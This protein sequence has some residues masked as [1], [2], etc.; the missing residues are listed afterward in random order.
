MCSPLLV[1]IV[2]LAIGNRLLDEE[3]APKADKAIDS[4]SV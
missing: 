1:T 3:C 2:M 4:F